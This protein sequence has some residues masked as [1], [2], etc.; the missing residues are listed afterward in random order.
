MAET[1]TITDLLDQIIQRY[2]PGGGFG[3]PERALLERE[4]TK[5]L[6]RTSQNLVSRGLAGTTAGVGMGKQ[7]EE[8]IGMPA[9]LRLE[10]VR[11]KRLMEALGTKAGYLEREQTRKGQTQLELYKIKQQTSTLAEQGLNAFGEPF[12]KTQPATGTGDAGGIT[13]HAGGGS[14]SLGGVGGD[15]SY[16]GGGMDWLSMYDP[17]GLA[18]TGPGEYLGTSG[19]M[20]AGVTAEEQKTLSADEAWNAFRQKNP[21]YFK[22]KDRWLRDNGYM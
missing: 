2:S 17:Q 1:Q 12:T 22:G 5:S 10:D 6:A 7:W 21:Y 16:G 14:F 20:S 18:S 13:T 19:E 9:K 3:D 11:S 15:D 8:E 4:K